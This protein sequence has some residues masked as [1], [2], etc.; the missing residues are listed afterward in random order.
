MCQLCGEGFLHEAGFHE[1]QREQHG[2]LQ[3]YR[4]EVLYHAAQAGC[5][6][7]TFQEKRSIVNAAAQFQVGC[8]P[9][10]GRNTWT[11][12]TGVYSPRCEVACVVCSRLDE[13]EH[14][15]PMKL[16]VVQPKN[17]DDKDMETIIDCDGIL[18]EASQPESRC[19]FT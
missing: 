16:F 19:L 12:T 13:A 15:N 1:H 4:N 7:L 17:K 18:E 5:Q 6:P 9:S 14:L 2:G 10:S 3:G 11:S 8:H